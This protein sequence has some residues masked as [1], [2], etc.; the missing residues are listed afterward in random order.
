MYS[1]EIAYQ[2]TDV[3]KAMQERKLQELKQ[4]LSGV[5]TET[6]LCLSSTTRDKDLIQS[7]RRFQMF[8]P[9]Y[10]VITKLDETEIYGNIFNIAVKSHIPLSY[11]TMGQRVPEDMEVATK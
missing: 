2:P 1:T 9:D 5:R 8:E 6:H 11:F 3:I 4:V 10:L 7:V